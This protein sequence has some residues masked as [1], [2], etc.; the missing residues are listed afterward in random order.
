MLTRISTVIVRRLATDASFGASGRGRG[1]AAA[2]VRGRPPRA[3][4]RITATCAS[5]AIAGRRAHGAAEDGVIRERVDRDRIAIAIFEIGECEPGHFAGRSTRHIDRAGGLWHLQGLR[6]ASDGREKRLGVSGLDPS[7]DGAPDAGPESA[8]GSASTRGLHGQER[9]V[10]DTRMTAKPDTR[11][12]AKPR[13]AAF[14]EGAGFEPAVRSRGLWFS[15][16][17]HSTALPPVRR[18]DRIGPDREPRFAPRWPAGQAGDRRRV[19]KTSRHPVASRFPLRRLRVR[20]G[21]Q[22]PGRRWPCDRRRAPTCQPA[23]LTG[24]ERLHTIDR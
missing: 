10:L 13:P 18:T 17:V 4:S 16:P 23:E 9:T 15:R 8:G 19:Q 12:T 3:G 6:P 1:S 21:H 2:A 20:H 22:R 7:E 5:C 14:T 11:M 24:H